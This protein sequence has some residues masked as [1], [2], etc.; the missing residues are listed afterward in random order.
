MVQTPVADITVTLHLPG[1]HNIYNAMAA[2]GAA[3]ALGIPTEAIKQGLEAVEQIKGRMEWVE[4][5]AAA[6]L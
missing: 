3:L 5:G 2:V 1:K 6:R 4:G